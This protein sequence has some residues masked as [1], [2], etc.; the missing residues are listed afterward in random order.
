MFYK[1][2]HM[3]HLI[4]SLHRSYVGRPRWTD[5]ENELERGSHEQRHGRLPNVSAAPPERPGWCAM[6]SH[7][8]SCHDGPHLEGEPPDGPRGRSSAP[9]S[10][11]PSSPHALPGVCGSEVLV[12]SQDRALRVRLFRRPSGP[13]R[14]RISLR[15]NSSSTPH[16]PET[17]PDMQEVPV[18][19]AGW[20]HTLI[21]ASD[22]SLMATLTF[23]GRRDV[24]A[25]AV[26]RTAPQRSS[27]PSDPCRAGE[28]QIFQGGGPRGRGRCSGSSQAWR[29]EDPQLV[30]LI[31]LMR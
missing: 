12:P 15:L 26:C 3:H 21:N 11:A 13:Q 30:Q 2:A 29:E 7:S 16:H 27:K 28:R 10:G 5:G 14:Q 25:V 19:S 6:L 31:S 17:G 18:K 1:L 24:P 4:L 22:S 23:G 20:T 8:S 9:P